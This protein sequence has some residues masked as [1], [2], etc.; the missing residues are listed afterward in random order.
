MPEGEL[1][2]KELLGGDAVGA[3]L[4]STIRSAVGHAQALAG[5]NPL[6]LQPITTEAQRALASVL[7]VSLGDILESAWATAGKL[8]EAADPARHKPDETVIVP[9]V[10]HTVRSKQEPVL[11]FT[12]DGRPVFS[13]SLSIELVL[14]L[15]GVVL[16][17]RGG[18][19]RDIASGTCSASAALSVA[20][21]KLIERSTREIM[22]PMRVHLGRG[23]GIPE[24]RRRTMKQT[25]PD[26]TWTEVPMSRR[27][28]AGLL[29]V[30]IVL[31]TLGVLTGALLL[32]PDQV[33]VTGILL[34]W[35]TQLLPVVAGATPG[36]LMMGLRLTDE[37]GG[38]IAVPGLL[39]RAIMLLAAVVTFRFRPDASGL[40]P[41]D[42]ISKT[43]VV[44]ELANEPVEASQRKA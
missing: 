10:E 27:L 36:M 26:P 11:E 14:R 9:M 22:L 32:P 35:A 17:V 18:R 23:I 20:G 38:T 29:D 30:A 24:L 43:R 16:R 4:Q 44:N 31:L 2:L 12:C 37:A 33:I 19:I 5:F 8:R 15:A 39:F 34:W 41:H 3:R 7:D 21:V 13:L 6:D 40:L 1:T 25:P 42:R 28:V